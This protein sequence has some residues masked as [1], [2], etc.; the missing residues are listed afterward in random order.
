[1][2]E[3]RGGYR[4]REKPTRT[5]LSVILEARTSPNFSPCLSHCVTL[6][7]CF[8][9][10]RRCSHSMVRSGSQSLSFRAAAAV[11]SPQRLG[12][13]DGVTRGWP[14]RSAP[15]PGHRRAGHFL[16]FVPFPY[17]PQKC[18]D[19]QTE[20]QADRESHMRADRLLE[21]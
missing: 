16:C 4:Q 15:A 8:S 19:G 1:M 18:S 21:K 6:K 11:N 14:L 10:T 9:V 17:V 5:K 2:A 20:R 7:T 13:S 12:N 3:K